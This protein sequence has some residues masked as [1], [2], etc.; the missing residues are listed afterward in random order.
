MKRFLALALISFTAA[1]GGGGGGDDTGDDVQDP[2]ADV[3]DDPDAEV[4]HQCFAD[5]SYT[6]ALGNMAATSGGGTAAAPDG[7]TGQATLNAAEPF[8][9]LQLELIKGY[10]V[11]TADITVGEHTLSGDELNYATCGLCPRLFT[12]CTQTAC[13][14]QQFYATGGT[15]NVTQITPNLQFT[16]TNLT[17]VEVTINE[18]TFESTPV[19][20]GCSTSIPNATFDGVNTHTP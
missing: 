12:D 15:I 14:D 1:C 10:G 4:A 11:Y 17:F 19:P 13:N 18:T 20:G 7:V 8:D 6:A 9:I 2:D 5:T 3:G 16:A